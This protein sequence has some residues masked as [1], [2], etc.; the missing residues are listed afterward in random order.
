M[1]EKKF[2]PF[3]KWSGGKSKE[4]NKVVKWMPEE[5]DTFYEPFVGGGAVWLGLAPEKSVICDYYDEVTNFFDVLKKHGKSFF[6]ECNAISSDY[7]AKFKKNVIGAFDNEISKKDKK[8]K[9]Y[10]IKQEQV[11]LKNLMKFLKNC[12]K[13]HLLVKN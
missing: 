6:D 5:Y 1:I 3:F 4:F 7:N 2:K 10:L 9:E 13:K 8:L 12:C 11:F